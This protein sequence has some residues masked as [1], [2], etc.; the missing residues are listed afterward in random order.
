MVRDM[1]VLRAVDAR[2][3][4]GKLRVQESAPALYFEVGATYGYRA[5][6]VGYNRTTHCDRHAPGRTEIL[7]ALTRESGTAWPP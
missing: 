4:C 1:A 7:G 6:V 3:G 2:I 5:A